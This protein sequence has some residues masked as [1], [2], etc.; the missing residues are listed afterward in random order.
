[1]KTKTALVL[2]LVIAA[3]GLAAAQQTTNLVTAIE[4]QGHDLVPLED[5]MAVISLAVGDEI[6]SDILLNDRYAI[7]E[8]GWFYDV[9]I[10]YEP[11]EEG[12][13][14]IYEVVENF[15]AQGLVVSGVESFPVAEIESL[16]DLPT[17][18]ILNTLKLGENLQAIM[19]K[20]HDEGYI[21]ARVRD[22]YLDDEGILHVEIN[23][24][25]LGEVIFEGL[26]KTKDRVVRREL[27][28]VEGQVFNAED[29]QQA[30]QRI[31]NLGYFTE[32]IGTR[33]EI[34]DPEGNKANVIVELEELDSGEFM[35]GGGYN[36][37]DG[38]MGSLELGDRNLF[39]YGQSASVKWEFGRNQTYELNFNEP[40]LFGRKCSL[41]F[42][43]YRHVI[44]DKETEKEDEDDEEEEG[45][46]FH[47]KEVNQGLGL[48]F[49]VPITNT[50][51]LSTRLRLDKTKKN[52][53]EDNP[54][55]DREDFEG[56]TRSISLTGIRDTTV[57]LFN[58]RSGARDSASVEFAGYLLGG[59][60]DFTKLN[61]ELRRYYPGFADNHSWALRLKGGVG[62]GKEGL[63]SHEL[64]RLGGDT[65]R[66]YEYGAFK[67]DAMVL[68]NAEYRFRIYSIFD[69]A[70]FFDL[71]N[72]WDKSESI[73]LKDI[74]PSLGAGLRMNTP[75]GQLRLD[76]GVSKEGIKPHFGI[77]QTF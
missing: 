70:V 31:Y 59:D 67:G 30:M 62:L 48:T 65:L 21:I 18:K 64:Y 3:G 36:T 16:I 8:L 17:G 24:G 27:L 1:M 60:Y 20:Y 71:G 5:I 44:N 47:F 35:F 41:G 28:L 34:A 75:L 19:E 57:D 66:G 54:P 63:P 46:H 33:L 39:G 2:I 25:Y 56:R 14:V 12:L 7:Y 74:K 45:T 52:W 9:D 37:K 72:A 55:S 53:H 43:L 68:F 10:R 49:G 13:K 22:I 42:N 61:L 29:I 6:D 40:Y 4:I 32:N 26:E 69:G 23:E 77:G 50:V 76:L 15:L 73:Q 51:R 58:P 38:W 11:Y